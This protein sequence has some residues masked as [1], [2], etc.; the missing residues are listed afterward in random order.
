MLNKELLLFNSAD[1]YAGA[2]L[3]LNLI[4]PVPE[5]SIQLT[6]IQI[7]SGEQL[8]RES[9]FKEGV[10]VRPFMKGR[11]YQL[12]IETAVVYI[13]DATNINGTGYSYYVVNTQNNAYLELHLRS[14]GGG[15]T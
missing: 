9:F 12:F 14:G 10:Y 2:N 3:T 11:Q 1:N 6:V 8:S 5:G 7:S 15:G 4:H 13:H